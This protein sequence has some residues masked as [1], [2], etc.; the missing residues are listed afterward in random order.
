MTVLVGNCKL[1]YFNLTALG[2]ACRVSLAMGGIKFKDERI[3]FPDWPAMKP[4]TPWG[5]LPMLT[6]ASGVEIG[7]QKAIIRLIGKETGLYPTDVIQA[8]H[9]DCIM[10]YGIDMSKTI[11]KI[12]ADLPKEEMLAKRAEAF[13]KGGD[14]YVLFERVEKYVTEHGSEGYA[15]GNSLT[16]ADA[17][18][19]AYVGL[20][21][22]GAFDGVPTNALD[23]DF[24]RLLSI[25]KNVRKVPGVDKYY[26]ELD[27]SIKI[28]ASYGPFN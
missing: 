26:K 22:S 20:V 25:R 28:A 8:A 5:T 9:V 13:A 2:E 27:A 21:V 17:F 24:P 11:R 7:Q 15:I 4:S 23:K 6:L 19:F 16:V 12:G 1:T 18:I 10:D 3:D 14:A